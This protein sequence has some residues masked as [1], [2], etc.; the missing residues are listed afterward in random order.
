MIDILII[1]AITYGMLNTNI[2]V[3]Y[4]AIG[5]AYI[6]MTIVFKAMEYALS[7]T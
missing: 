2:P 1:T 6:S 5:V 4:A 3:L 7:L